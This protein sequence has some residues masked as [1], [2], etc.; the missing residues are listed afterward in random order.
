[1]TRTSRSCGGRTWPSVPGTPRPGRV[2]AR[3]AG[4]TDSVSRRVPGP[5]G[6]QAAT[7]LLNTGEMLEAVKQGRIGDGLEKAL[8]LLRAWKF[9]K[10]VIVNTGNDVGVGE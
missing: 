3:R 9:E 7:T 8:K 2:A 5:R 1:M 4:R 10:A 6:Y